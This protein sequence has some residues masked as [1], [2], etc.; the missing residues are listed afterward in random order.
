MRKKKAIDKVA[1][2]VPVQSLLKKIERCKICKIH[3][4]GDL[5]QQVRSTVM[6]NR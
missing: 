6:V 5:A 4:V 2:H 1:E 3:I